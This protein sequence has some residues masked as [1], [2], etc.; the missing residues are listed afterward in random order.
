MRIWLAILLG[1]LCI[2]ITQAK[3]TAHGL[4]GINHVALAVR[5]IDKSIRFYTD[6]LGFKITMKKVYD[7]KENVTEV[8]VSL[9]KGTTAIELIQFHDKDKQLPPL[10][11]NQKP[12]LCPHIGLE[13]VDF[14]A[15]M[16]ML[17]ANHVK[18]ISGPTII[19]HDIKLVTIV[20]PDNYRIDIGQLL[21]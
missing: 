12:A 11:Q 15:T 21:P 16:K 13:S 19:P 8:N 14:D 10:I 20:D 17:K 18:I 1:M 7:K 6:K 5:N 9:G 2:S 3:T 4:S